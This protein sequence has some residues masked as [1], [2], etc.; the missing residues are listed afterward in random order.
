MVTFAMPPEHSGA[1]RQAIT[2]ATQ[3]SRSG[4]NVL[5]VT[6]R[7]TEASEG[8]DRVAGFQVL[9]VV[10]RNLRQ[11]AVAPLRVF[12][13]L[14]RERARFDVV[15]V[16][17]VGYLSSVAVFFGWCFGKAVVIKMT[18]FSEDDALSVRARRFGAITYFFYSRASRIVAITQSFYRSCVAAGIEESRLALIPNGVDT[19][20]FRPLASDKAALRRRLGLPAEGTLLVYAGIIRREKGIDFLL[21]VVAMLGARRRDVGLVLLGPVEPSLPEE[22]RRYAA[23]QLDRIERGDVRGL[24]H[25]KGGVGNVHEYFQAVDI[26]TSAS[27]REGFPNVVLEAMASGLPPVVLEVPDV[28]ANVLEDGVDSCIVTKP[29]RQVFLDRLLGLIEDA[30][31]RLRMGAAAQ[32]KARSRF[33]MR[34][35][36]DDYLALYASLVA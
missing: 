1:A 22:D 13:A 12:L 9:R 33:A 20:V 30:D 35:V 23:A 17:G 11:K 29:D 2:L 8:I 7:S 6:M 26:F 28:H 25:Y 31:L 27:T 4:A 32:E 14:F 10:K 3:L 21:D 19:E 15:H 34:K 36:A 5:F 24:V 16:H 18:M